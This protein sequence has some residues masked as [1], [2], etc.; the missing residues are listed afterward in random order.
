MAQDGGTIH[1]IEPYIIHD[2][3]LMDSEYIIIPGPDGD[4]LME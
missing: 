3:Q 2:R 4:S 1:G